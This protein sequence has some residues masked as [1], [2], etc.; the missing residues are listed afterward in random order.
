[1]LK[2][3]N[4]RFGIFSHVVDGFFCIKVAA[5]PQSLSMDLLGLETTPANQ[6][7]VTSLFETPAAPAVNNVGVFANPPPA[8]NGGLLDVFDP[9]PMGSEGDTNA[10]T[11]G[12]EEN[13]KK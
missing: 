4:S 11:P 3:Q 9:S 7:T 10:L 8:A 13:F 5:A 6:P 12:S 2:P 1:M